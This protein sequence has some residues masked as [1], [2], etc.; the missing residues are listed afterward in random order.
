MKASKI[1]VMYGLGLIAFVIFTIIFPVFTLITVSFFV[2]YTF[3]FGLSALFLL[4]VGISELIKTV[5]DCVKSS[6]IY[7]SNMVKK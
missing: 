3:I 6:F 5:I 4:F 1:E 2:I 7:F